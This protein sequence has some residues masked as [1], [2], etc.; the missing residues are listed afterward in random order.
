MSTPGTVVAPGTA[1]DERVR[2]GRYDLGLLAVAALAVGLRLPYLTGR[3]LWYDEASSWQTA[4]FPLG[5]LLDSV[6]LNVH[7]PLYY[8]LLKGWMAVLGESVVA[9][10]GFS[11]AFGVLTV[12]LMDRVAR[13]VFRASDREPP[14]D[15]ET[16]AARAFG[17]AVAALVAASP[18]QVYASI[19][20]R[21]YTLGTALT[22]LSSWL[23]LRVLRVRGR[24][25]PWVPYGLA[26]V[27][28]LYTHHYGL[29]TVAAQFAFLTLWAAWLLG[30]GRGEEV[31]AVL[32]PA[33]AVGV[34]VAVLYLPG[35]DILRGQVGRVRQDYWIRPLSW[36]TVARTF[37]EFAVPTAGEGSQAG[38]WA[39]LVASA[40]AAAVLATGGR[41][42]D[43]F[44]LASWLLP[45][46]FSAA[47]STS[48]PVWVPRYFRFAHL[49]A[50]AAVALAIWRLTRPAPALRGP[51]TGLLLAGLLAGD[52]A[53]WRSLDIPHAPG[54]RGAVQAAL[55]GRRADEAIVAF[56]MY[57]YFPAKYYIGPRAPVRLLEPTL[58]MF[59]GGHLIRPGDLITPEELGRALPHGVWTIG[60]L[61]DPPA[62]IPELARA[63]TERV[64]VFPYYDDLHKRV[65]LHHFLAPDRGRPG[66][67]A[68]GSSESDDPR[69]GAGRLQMESSR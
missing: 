11:I 62:V 23:L 17:L 15:R 46:L 10:R 4:K 63:S 33:A 6:R 20:A 51:L 36:G 18:Y 66:A 34:A 16:P 29:F 57:Q 14:G 65:Y 13:E 21:M 40:V 64:Q 41:R 43:W 55:A 35:L 12:L 48:T 25:R 58:D 45:M 47:V 3:S 28:L 39:V 26:C 22:A 53:F 69:P 49:F 61:P 42:G 1:G 44:V 54:V 2:L 37:S 27:A 60:R 67:A 38:G 19:E 59:W 52:V 9:L 24:S 8:V 68:H 5:G 7:M 32:I 30:L 50:L 56:D 31:R